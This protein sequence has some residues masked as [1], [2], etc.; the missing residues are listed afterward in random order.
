MPQERAVL[1]QDTPGHA[2]RM[3][4]DLAIRLVLLGVKSP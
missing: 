4:S 1:T 2:A 3:Q